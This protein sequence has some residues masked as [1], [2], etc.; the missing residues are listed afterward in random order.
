MPVIRLIHVKVEPGQIAEVER[1]WNE[2]CAPLMIQQQGCTSEQLLKC[3]DNP[4]EFISYSEWESQAAI[5]RYRE[6]EDHKT[7]QSH[8]RGLQGARAVVKQ[9]EAVK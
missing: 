4:G 7:I 8:S 3:I 6:S 9:Y 5:D 2:D 1:I